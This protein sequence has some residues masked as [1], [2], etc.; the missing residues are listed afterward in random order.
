MNKSV[1]ILIP[2]RA[3][4]KGVLGK[5]K[6]NVGGK[7][8]VS[9]SIEAATASKLATHIAV[10]TDDPDIAAIARKANIGVIERPSGISEDS[11]PV[12]LAVRHALSDLEARG[13]SNFSAVVLLQPTSPLR[14][15]ADIDGA[16]ELFLE[17]GNPV[18]SVSRCNDNHPA[19]MYLIESGKLTPLMPDQSSLRRQDLP[20][21][22][23]RNGAIYVFGKTEIGSGNIVSL[24]MVP[25]VMDS[26]VAINVDSEFDLLML[27][28]FLKHNTWTF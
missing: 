27:E 7:P 24:N 12:I 1:L 16:I 20:A 5:N 23:H 21:V 8:L 15:G 4:S 26:N 25:Y 11:S 17:S 18:C 28:T 13:F 3:N 22:Y 9:Y 14:K 19:R 10:T 6:R 2:A